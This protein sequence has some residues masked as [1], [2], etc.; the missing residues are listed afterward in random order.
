MDTL[1]QILIVEDEWVIAEDCAVCLRQ[2]GYGVGGPFPTAA[3]ALGYLEDHSVDAALLDVRLVG[4]ESG[5]V[6]D[7][8]VARAIP[9][10]FM[11]GYTAK[12][13]PPRFDGKPIV[14]KPASHSAILKALE[15]LLDPS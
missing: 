13:I 9:F 7:A 11:T 1:R 5:A 3:A 6:A 10:A 8:L 14:P 12:G 2:A 4:E 15:R